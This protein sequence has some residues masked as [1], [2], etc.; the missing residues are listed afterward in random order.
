M[1][2][3][4]NMEEEEEENMQ[5]E[6]ENM[7]ETPASRQYVGYVDPLGKSTR[8]LFRGPGPAS[9]RSLY[10]SPRSFYP[11]LGHSVHYRDR[12]WVRTPGSGSPWV[13]P[14]SPILADW[15]NEYGPGYRAYLPPGAVSRDP[16]IYDARCDPTPSVH[17]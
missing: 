5:D 16:G 3:L 6:E 13:R 1:Y 4:H 8:D 7:D 17:S 2:H 9:P 15:K 14:R 11:R 10:P 12:G